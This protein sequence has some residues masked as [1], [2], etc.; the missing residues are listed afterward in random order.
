MAATVYR[1]PSDGRARWGDAPASVRTLTGHL[2]KLCEVKMAGRVDDLRA[3]YDHLGA[4][5]A[6]ETD[7]A[8]A[9]ALTR[10]RR[11]IGELLEGLE[12]PTEVPFVDQLAARRRATAGDASRRRKPG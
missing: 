12:T 5:L 3:D 7:G 8:K 2:S 9:A 4:L 11:L 10:E 1:S 6:Q